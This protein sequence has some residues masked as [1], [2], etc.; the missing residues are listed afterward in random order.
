MVVNALR[1]GYG[2]LLLA[3]LPLAGAVV[4]GIWIA[5]WAALALGLVTLVALFAI[6]YLALHMDDGWLEHKQFERF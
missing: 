1:S 6:G 2:W 3:V 4:L 5:W